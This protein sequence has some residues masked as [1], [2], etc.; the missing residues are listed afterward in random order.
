MTGPNGLGHESAGVIIAVGPEVKSLKVGDRVAI[1]CGIPC[2]KATCYYC[3]NG[4]YNACPDVV[5]W[6]TLPYHGTLTRY[7]VHPEEWLRKIPDN[8][9][10]E[11]GSLLEP[12]SVALAGIE[13][14]NLRL[15]DPLLICVTLGLLAS[16]HSWQHPRQGRIRSSLPTSTSLDCVPLR[17]WYRV[18]LPSTLPLTWDLRMLLLRS[19]RLWAERPN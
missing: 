6:S 15:G 10:F 3:R 7:H 11:Q 9:S 4:R 8:M 18:S 1:E 5:F 17:T 12:L 13:R 2:M 19:R 16:H 14:S